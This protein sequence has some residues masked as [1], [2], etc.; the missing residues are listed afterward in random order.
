MDSEEQT[1]P[2]APRHLKSAG[3]FH[4]VDSNAFSAHYA[5]KIPLEI[6]EDAPA[7]ESGPKRRAS[8]ESIQAAKARTPQKNRTDISLVN[9]G[10]NGR[11]ELTHEAKRKVAL[12]VVILTLVAIAVMSVGL[13]F[14][15]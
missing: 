3:L 14:L 2:A 12:A 6:V 9:T 15:R 1:L 4:P 13:V 10:A 8:A 11:R 5:A 7:A